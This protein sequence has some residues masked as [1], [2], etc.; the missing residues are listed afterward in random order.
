MLFADDFVGVSDSKESLQKLIDIVY[1]Y[2]S[3]WRLQANVNKSAVLVLSK[4]TV[5]GC[6]VIITIILENHEFLIIVIS[7]LF[8][9]AHTF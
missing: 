3:N 9:V 2:C 1:S 6:F 4:D 8:V 7:R 5:N